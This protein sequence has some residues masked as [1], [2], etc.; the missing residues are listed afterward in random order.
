MVTDAWSIRWVSSA[1]KSLK[2]LHKK[3]RH[4]IDVDHIGVYSGIMLRSQ[5]LHLVIFNQKKRAFL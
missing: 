4:K 5:K 3:I 2:R 1:K